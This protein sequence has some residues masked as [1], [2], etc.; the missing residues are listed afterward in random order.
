MENIWKRVPK[1]DTDKVVLEANIMDLQSAIPLIEKE[2]QRQSDEHISKHT[3][4]SMDKKGAR[5]Q[6]EV[7]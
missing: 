7:D 4:V 1:D 5:K 3:K 2:V 6:N